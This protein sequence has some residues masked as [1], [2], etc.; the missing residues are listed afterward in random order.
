MNLGLRWD[1]ETPLT[2]ANNEYSRV[3]P[4]TGQVL[5][6]GQNGVSDTLNLAS[7]KLNFA[8]RIGV[9][10]NIRPKTVIRSGFGIFYAGFFSDL[11]GQVEFPGYNVEQS[12]TSLGTGKP[13]PFTLS[14]GMPSVVTNNPSESASQHRPIQQP[15]E[16]SD[17]HR[18]RPASRK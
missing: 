17:A 6:A 3:D 2:T 1:Y 12:F 15:F 9:A 7:A 4:T 13:Q 18:L 5:F 16:S 11:G 10:Y 14:Q 8:P